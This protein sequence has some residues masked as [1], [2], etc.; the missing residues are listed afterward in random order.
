MNNVKTQILEAVN[1]LPEDTTWEDAIYTLYIRKK[2]AMGLKAI[3]EGKVISH[4]DLRKE[5]E[6][7]K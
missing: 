1:A 6:T 3:E 7:W 4:E 5:V 2:I